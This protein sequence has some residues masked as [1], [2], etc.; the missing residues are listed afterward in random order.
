MNKFR[1]LLVLTAFIVMLTA[2]CD[3]K[4]ENDEETKT[5][6][7]NNDTIIENDK[8]NETEIIE[9]EEENTKTSE[10]DSVKYLTATFDQYYCGDDCSYIFNY[11]NE[12][13]EEKQV[14][15]ISL[16]QYGREKDNLAKSVNEIE[17]MFR[18]AKNKGKKFRLK[19]VSVIVEP[20]CDLCDTSVY[21]AIDDFE[22][23]GE[24]PVTAAYTDYQMGDYSY[25]EFTTKLGYKYYFNEILKNSTGKELEYFSD[26]TPYGAPN[27]ELVGKKFKIYFHSEIT[28]NDYVGGEMEYFIID[29]IELL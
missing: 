24:S 23:I 10:T 5:E 6:I 11:V 28:E 16:T 4:N 14:Y 7:K 9:P 20:E 1:L 25:Y 27:K 15:F 3:E 8:I 2:S 21:N 22:L 12:S 18:Y 19:Y 29:N 26:D 13:E 17:E